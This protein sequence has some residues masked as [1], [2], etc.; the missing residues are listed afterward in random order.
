[1][2]VLLGL[3]S[4]SDFSFTSLSVDGQQ[5]QDGCIAQNMRSV[6]IFDDF[7]FMFSVI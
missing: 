4:D 2:S 1:M 5:Y 6:K 7:N 3:V